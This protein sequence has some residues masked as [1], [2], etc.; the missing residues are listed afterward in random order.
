MSVV[1]DSFE[2]AEVTCKSNVYFDGKVIS[3]AIKTSEGIRKTLGI[4]LPGSYHFGTEAAEEMQLSGG[5][6][7]VKLAGSEVWNSYAAGE[8]F[9]IPA[10]SAFDITVE[11]SPMDYICTYLD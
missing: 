8:M 7:K 1:P 9:A 10:N 11:D 2:N 3:H 6:C 4:I 5:A